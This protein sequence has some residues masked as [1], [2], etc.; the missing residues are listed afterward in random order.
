MARLHDNDRNGVPVTNTATYRPG[1]A[2]PAGRIPARAFWSPR[3][4]PM[5][6][7]QQ[8]RTAA[9]GTV[10]SES[11]PAVG[12]ARYAPRVGVSLRPSPRWGLW[13][14]GA[15]VLLAAATVGVFQFVPPPAPYVNFRNQ[16]VLIVHRLGFF[17]DP[18]PAAKP[19]ETV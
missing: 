11:F 12:P 8:P 17:N 4:E 7:P 2:P 1:N 10:N 14:G 5:P 19:A 16:V 9:W 13:L 3:D 6:N 15:L 18:A